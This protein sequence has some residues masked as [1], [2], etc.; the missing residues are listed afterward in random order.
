MADDLA[1]MTAALIEWWRRT[2]RGVMARIPPPTGQP[3]GLFL[4]AQSGAANHPAF[5]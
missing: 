2:P 5:T 3:A 1:G 4:F